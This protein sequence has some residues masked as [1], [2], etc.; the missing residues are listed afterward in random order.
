MPTKREDAQI[1]TSLPKGKP[2]Y[3]DTVQ[4]WD[5]YLEQNKLTTKQL[6]T[7]IRHLKQEKPEF[8]NIK[9]M[10]QHLETIQQSLEN[11]LQK[12]ENEFESKRIPLAQMITQTADP[13][14]VSK[15]PEK[16]A[17]IYPSANARERPRIPP[18][19]TWN[20]KWAGKYQDHIN[21]LN[22]EKQLI[23]FAQSLGEE[24]INLRF[25]KAVDQ[26]IKVR[27]KELGV[28]KKISLEPN[29]KEA[30]AILGYKNKKRPQ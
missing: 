8:K 20:E 27:C 19:D 18:L 26:M 11:T 9:P 21:T 22:S 28:T 10:L 25:L 24:D 12:A 5:I 1:I 4:K 14:S 13:K 15:E 23:S 6:E 17:P 3:N 29:I 2:D 7:L 16:A 30:E